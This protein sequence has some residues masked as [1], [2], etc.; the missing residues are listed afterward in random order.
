MISQWRDIIVLHSLAHLP[1][2]IW[3]S[4]SLMLMEA[5]MMTIMNMVHVSHGRRKRSLLSLI[6][7]CDPLTPPPPSPFPP[8]PFP[9]LLRCK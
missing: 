4:P 2:V 1:H 8:L 7:I 3:M 6:W 9:P 5:S